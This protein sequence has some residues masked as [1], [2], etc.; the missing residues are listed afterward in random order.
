MK[1]KYTLILLLCLYSFSLKAQSNKVFMEFEDNRK[2]HIYT[3]DLHYFKEVFKE[4]LKDNGFNISYDKWQDSQLNIKV[5][6]KDLNFYPETSDNLRG[7]YSVDIQVFNPMNKAMSPP[8]YHVSSDVFIPNYPIALYYH[9]Q[10]MMKY[11]IKSRS[12]I[13]KLN[14]QIFEKLTPLLTVH[15]P[16]VED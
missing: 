1:P 7:K 9:P 3:L 12:V 10:Y 15:L 16:C 8:S 4:S 14:S 2:S 11:M 5:K 13:K 6:I